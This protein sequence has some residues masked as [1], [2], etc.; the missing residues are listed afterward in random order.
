[1]APVLYHENYIFNNTL[2]DRPN[3]LATGLFFGDGILN[4]F[5]GGPN[6]AVGSVSFNLTST[7]SVTSVDGQD[8]ATKV[9]QAPLSISGPLVADLQTEYQVAVS[10]FR[11]QGE[12]TA[13]SPEMTLL[14]RTHAVASC[15][16]PVTSNSSFPTR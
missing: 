13:V 1:M 12:R 9:C 2:F 14:V 16:I 4:C 11:P 3:K 8:L 6:S 7:N 15:I 10:A 5:N